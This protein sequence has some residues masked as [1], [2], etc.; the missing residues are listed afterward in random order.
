M[1]CSKVIATRCSLGLAIKPLRLVPFFVFSICSSLFFVTAMLFVFVPREECYVTYVMCSR[2]V[3][4]NMCYV[5][6][7]LSCVG[8]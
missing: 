8:V 4:C 7:F 1:C 6:M 2:R 3:L 5:F